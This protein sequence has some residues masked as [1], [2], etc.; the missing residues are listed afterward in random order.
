MRV[1]AAQSPPAG[2]AWR[3]VQLS[4]PSARNVGDLYQRRLPRERQH[5]VDCDPSA[6]RC[7]AQLCFTD[8][9]VIRSV[10]SVATS[11]NIRRISFS[12]RYRLGLTVC[13]GG[14]AILGDPTDLRMILNDGVFSLNKDDPAIDGWACS[15]DNFAGVTG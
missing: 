3:D 1:T 6:D 8:R 7:V 4:Q 5:L 14:D 2:R 9:W 12:F 10:P 11:L 13:D 15:E